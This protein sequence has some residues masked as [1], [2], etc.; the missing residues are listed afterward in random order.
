MIIGT[1]ISTNM[2]FYDKELN[3]F[4]QEASSLGNALLTGRLYDDA[5]DQGFVLVS[6]KT[7]KEVAFYLESTQF[8]NEELVSWKFHSVSDRVPSGDSYTV[9]VW[10]D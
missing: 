8:E 9:R 5:C 7:G 10:N 6:H 4:S 1:K 3:Q 2:F